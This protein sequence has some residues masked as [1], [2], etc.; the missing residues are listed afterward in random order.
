MNKS[1][2]TKLRNGL[3]LWFGLSVSGVAGAGDEHP[4]FEMLRDVTRCTAESFE[5]FDGTKLRAAI[6]DA[7]SKGL[8]VDASTDQAINPHGAPL[9]IKFV[10]PLEVFGQ[11][12]IGWTVTASSPGVAMVFDA[13]VDQV[14]QGV[15]SSGLAFPCKFNPTIDGETI[16][17]ATYCESVRT[18]ASRGES[19]SFRLVLL[20][21][22]GRLRAK[23][24]ALECYF[25]ARR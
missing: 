7:S 13:R 19:L 1:S 11:K 20:D 23:H 12:W 16:P 3:A 22:P 6:D 4:L 2:S 25:S 5:R 14:A 18:G 24:P 15:R 9:A 21:M 8:V 17:G 10:R